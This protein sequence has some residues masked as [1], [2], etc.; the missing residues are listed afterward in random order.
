MVYRK[1][2]IN[3]LGEV[4]ELV[5]LAI[6]EME[7]SEIHQWDDI[8][9][10]K[11]HLKADI[12]TN[13]L[14]VGIQDEKIAVIYVV[15]NDCDEQYQNGKWQYPESEFRVIHRLCVSPEFQHRGIAK[16]TLSHIE[17]DLRGRGVCS[18]RLDVFSQ[19][20]YALKLY[21]NAGYNEVGTAEWRKG[22]FLLMEKHL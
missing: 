22:K 11:E 3:D 18:V 19:N 8:Y 15:N 7:R 1:A 5:T 14:S 9:P 10:A 4:F 16:R 17:D 6:E 21:Q 12:E 13:T 20:P 2:D